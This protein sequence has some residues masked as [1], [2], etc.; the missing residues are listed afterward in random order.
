[1]EESYKT[2]QKEE[3]GEPM[4]KI[5]FGLVGAGWR[6]E[7]F[8][9]IAK[10]LPERFKVSGVVVR[11]EEKARLLENKW[12]VRTYRNW[13]ALVD[14]ST[15]SFVVLSVPWGATPVLIGE[16]CG[17]GVPVLSET[18][19][20]P[21]LES[22]IRLNEQVGN[23]AK[24][25]VAEQYQFQP[26][27]AAQLAVVNSNRL[28]KISQ[29]QISVAH[30]YHGMSLMRKFLGVQYEQAEIQAFGFDS[31]IISGPNRQG[32]PAEYRLQ[33]SNQVVAAL[34]FGEK[35]GIYDFC[36]DQYFSWIRS[37]RLLVRG[38]NGEINYDQV[39]YLQDYA[40]PVR[41]ELMRI[42]AG[43]RGNL[44]GFHLKG[45]ALGSDDIYRNPF[46][47]GRFSD[48]EI[49]VATCL[50]RMGDYVNGGPGFY[51]LAE[52]SQDHYLSLMINRAIQTKQT[53]VAGKQPWAAQTVS[54][55]G[56]GH[57]D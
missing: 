43:H 38:E 48:D 31:P 42:D 50:E 3:A 28:G 40:T 29:A 11:D 45:I 24:I 55:E 30:G 16:L 5:V 32:P 22:L 26:L 33:S 6:S 47:P 36:G 8:L 52:A 51:S 1:M 23:R 14:Q 27:Y 53:V 25:Q 49:A 34:R 21:D 12:G 15:P 35:L 54:N 39:S 20:A 46:I 9:R 13:R 56:G 2:A 17:E 57:N 19:P 10:E 44:E 37:P 7:F 41:L 18:P 4:R